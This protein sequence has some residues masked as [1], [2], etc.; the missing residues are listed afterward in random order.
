MKHWFQEWPCICNRGDK[1]WHAH[2]ADD[3]KHRCGRCSDECSGYRLDI[4]EAV[5]IRIL[6]GPVMSNIEAADIL[7]GPAASEGQK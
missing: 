3:E 7:L 6:L 4:P 1:V 5:A 2:Y